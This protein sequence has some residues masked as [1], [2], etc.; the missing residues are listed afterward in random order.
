MKRSGGVEWRNEQMDELQ[1]DAVFQ[2]KANACCC[3]YYY[4]SSIFIIFNCKQTL[5]H[6]QHANFLLLFQQNG[7][8]L[9]S[10]CSRVGALATWHTSIHLH[11][12]AHIY[13]VITGW[14]KLFDSGWLALYSHL[15]SLPIYLPPFPLSVNFSMQMYGECHIYLFRISKTWEHPI[16]SSTY[17]YEY[18]CTLEYDVS[19]WTTSKHFALFLFSYRWHLHK[20]LKAF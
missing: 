15:F 2:A 11:R 10:K 12:L 8:S 1:V 17:V 18:E 19:N 16:H 5:W 6:Q 9:K 7:I 13:K 20:T 3:C 14:V 4:C